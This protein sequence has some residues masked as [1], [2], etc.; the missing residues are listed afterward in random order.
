MKKTSDCINSS[1]LQLKENLLG[2]SQSNTVD[3]TLKETKFVFLSF[4]HASTQ[5]RDKSA[6]LGNHIS[7]SPA[8][9]LPS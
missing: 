6:L 2:V 9:H 1:T 8:L 5:Q 7:H 4:G 3:L